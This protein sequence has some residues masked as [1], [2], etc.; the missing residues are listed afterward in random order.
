MKMFY[1]KDTDANL[2][3]NKKIAIFGYGSQ[4]HAHALNLKD[5]GVKEVVVALRD[6]SSTLTYAELLFEVQSLAGCMH[7][8]GVAP[9][10]TIGLVG[11]YDTQ[12][13]IGLHAIGWLGAVAFPLSADVSQDEALAQAGAAG[14]KVWLADD[15][16]KVALTFC[17]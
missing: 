11:T 4:G 3:K 14:V 15:I 13:V 7:E 10:D 16:W 9:G 5:S 17:F 6:G 8:L 1:E 12:W 2:I